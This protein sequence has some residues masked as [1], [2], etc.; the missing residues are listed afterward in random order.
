MAARRRSN[1][2]KRHS[3]SGGGSSLPYVVGA[4]IALGLLDGAGW[5]MSRTATVMAVDDA[6]LCPLSTGPVAET[7]I[8]SDL[9]DPLSA[10][11]SSQL[12]QYI[13]A[14]F[15]DTTTGTQ[16]TLG[17]LSET[18]SDWGR[19]RCALQARVGKGRQQHDAERGTGEETP[20]AAIR[21]RWENVITVTPSGVTT[22]NPLI[23]VLELPPMPK[24]LPANSIDPITL[25]A[26]SEKTTGLIS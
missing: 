8:L 23:A 15:T 22:W 25:P 4:I 10:A 17:V 13:E 3:R 26:L 7:A 16:F 19:Y 18:A 24:G 11:Q 6:T 2:G 9:T 5:W 1:F 12:R 21:A 20:S 14:E